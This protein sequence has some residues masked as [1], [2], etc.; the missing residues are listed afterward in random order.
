ME[1]K[2]QGVEENEGDELTR[3]ENEAQPPEDWWEWWC[4][5]WT[6]AADTTSVYVQ[7]I[8]LVSFFYL[9]QGGNVFTVF[10]SLLVGLR[11]KN[12]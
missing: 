3:D 4:A 12:C 11:K 6:R 2:S 9:S 10:V 8:V 7:L 1:W 5:G